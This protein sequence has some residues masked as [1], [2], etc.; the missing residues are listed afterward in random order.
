MDIAAITGDA[1]MFHVDCAQAVYGP[2]T[3]EL[4]IKGY[5]MPD[6]EKN[7]IGIVLE[8]SAD[9]LLKNGQPGSCG[10]CLGYITADTRE[11]GNTLARDILNLTAEYREDDTTRVL[12][13]LAH[14]VRERMA[15]GDLVIAYLDILPYAASLSDVWGEDDARTLAVRSVLRLIN[16]YCREHQLPLDNAL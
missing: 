1:Q 4:V 16:D 6:E 14:Y 8:G 13:A 5:E 12:S 7:P 9:L 10:K 15:D 11:D 2:R 3:I